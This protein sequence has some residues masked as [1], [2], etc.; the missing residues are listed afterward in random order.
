MNTVNRLESGDTRLL[1][2]KD[3]IFS[4]ETVTVLCLSETAMMRTLGGNFVWMVTRLWK[5][6]QTF[7]P[8]NSM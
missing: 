1:S 7:W 6:A 2:N 3:L 5:A 4:P 8:S